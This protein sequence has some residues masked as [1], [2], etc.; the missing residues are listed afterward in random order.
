M[1]LRRRVRSR[2]VPGGRL[3]GVT[4]LLVCLATVPAA[5][6][7]PRHVYLTWQS[8]PATSITVNVHT[9]G[10]DATPVVVRY[11]TVSHSGVPALYADS[12][13]AVGRPAPGAVRR[14]HAAEL[15]GLRPDRTY[16][17]VVGNQALGFSRERAFRTLPAGD[18]PLRFV[19]GGDMGVGLLAR[20]LQAA[21]A[22]QDPRF[23]VVGGDLAYANGDWAQVGVWDAWFDNW[24]TLMVTPAGLTVPIVAVIGNHE[25]AGGYQGTPDDA[26]LFLGFLPQGTDRTYYVR[27]LGTRLALYVL[28]SGHVAPHDGAQA[29]WLAAQLATD[30]DRPVKLAA[31]HVPLFPSFRLPSSG[32]ASRGRRAWQ[33]LFDRHGLMA[34]FEHHDHAFKRTYPIRG[35]RIDPR[36]TLYL[37]D[38]AWGRGPRI[39]TGPRQTYLARRWYLDELAGRGH[40]WRVDVAGDSVIFAA[41]DT[42]GR[43]F[44][45]VARVVGTSR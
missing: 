6:A 2:P 33:P 9:L 1:S 23:A 11:D 42:S 21:A 34:A 15:T 5:A 38:G 43:V 25:V 37:G 12:A 36:G 20:R 30:R 3:R 31:Y 27:R 13:L 26:A 8:D 10:A 32:W 24:D 18:A 35:D 17:F 29:D 19:V 44:D 14:L 22:A 28:D 7:G 40:V 39:V 16:W 4:A 41:I 45:R